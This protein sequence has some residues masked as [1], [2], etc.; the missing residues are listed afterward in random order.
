MSQK[1]INQ[2]QNNLLIM[3]YPVYNYT[4]Q[5]WEDNKE[6]LKIQINEK[7][8]SLKNKEYLRMIGLSNEEADY[9][10]SRHNKVLESMK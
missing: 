2:S 6:A 10:I 5:K 8:E 1:L 3:K 7:I 4:T 9:H